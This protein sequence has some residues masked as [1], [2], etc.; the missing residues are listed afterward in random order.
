M[1]RGRWFCYWATSIVHAE[2]C[3]DPLCLRG[4]INTRFVSFDSISLFFDVFCVHANLQLYLQ[5][6]VRLPNISVVFLFLRL[7]AAAPS[8]FKQ[9][10]R[11]VM[12]LSALI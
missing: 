12:S 3:L 5:R 11:L 9:H 1:C 6:K 7:K 10:I 8:F 4:L 2:L